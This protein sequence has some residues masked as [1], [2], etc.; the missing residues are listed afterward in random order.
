MRNY[1]GILILLVG[2]SH[3][4]QPPTPYFSLQD[5]HRG[6]IPP[7]QIRQYPVFRQPVHRQP[8]INYGLING[9]FY[10]HYP[11]GN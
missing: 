8:R 3:I 6:T 5:Y 9:R 7:A 2:F 10:W 1:P 4:P 11:L